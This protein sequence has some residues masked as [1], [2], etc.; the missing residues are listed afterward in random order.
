MPITFSGAPYPADP[1]EFSYLSRRL[2]NNASGAATGTGA[3]A[4]RTIANGYFDGDI[5]TSALSGSFYRITIVN[6]SLTHSFDT[7]GVVDLRS[8]W[9]LMFRTI[10]NGNTGNSHFLFSVGGNAAGGV[11]TTGINVGIEIPNATTARLWQCNNTTPV[12]SE[13]AALPTPIAASVPTGDHFFWLDCIGASNRLELFCAFKPYG[14]I[15]PDKPKVP[16]CS[17]SNIPA[18]LTS[19]RGLTVLV[20]ATETSPAVFTS[21]SL[22]D[23]VFTEY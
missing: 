3:T 16:L 15:M 13:A 5:S 6:G 12:Y 14:S 20:R 22:R 17:L 8:S 19:D 10:L 4:R 9:S 11:P 2:I 18:A 1:Y 23:C 7:P 21:L